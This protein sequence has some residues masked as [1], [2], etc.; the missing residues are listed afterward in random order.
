MS[1]IK[2]TWYGPGN[3]VTA[4]RFFLTRTHHQQTTLEEIEF[5][6]MNLANRL[7]TMKLIDRNIVRLLL[8]KKV[9]VI[10][11]QTGNLYVIREAEHD[12]G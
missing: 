1:D 8:L 9:Y 3:Q 11:R 5:M 6:D 10:R 2:S 4:H 7:E 12:L